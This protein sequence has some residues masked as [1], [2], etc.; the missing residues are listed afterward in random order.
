MKRGFTLLELIVV[1]IILGILATLGFSQY[2]RMIERSRGAEA[3]QVCGSI[4]TQVAALYIEGGSIIPTPVAP[5]T[6]NDFVG[7]GANAGQISS[8]CL[9]ANPNAVQYYFS[10]NAVRDS[11]TGFTVTATRC[12]ANGKAPQGPAA[13]TLTLKTDLTAGTDVWGGT[14]GY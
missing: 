11:N 1:I 6:F 8:G 2:T 13:L 5:A 14:G 7:I 10:Y 3:R 12:T 4:R 9:A